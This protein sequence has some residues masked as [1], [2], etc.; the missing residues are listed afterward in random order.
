MNWLKRRYWN[1]VLAFAV[2]VGVLLGS[3]VS[4]GA[5]RDPAMDPHKGIREDTLRLIALGTPDDLLRL[6]DAF[7]KTEQEI[8]RLKLGAMQPEKQ[9]QLNAMRDRH[10]E[11]ETLLRLLDSSASE[12][13]DRD[14]DRSSAQE[15]ASLRARLVGR[16]EALQESIGVIEQAI[17]V[18]QAEYLRILEDERRAL[19]RFLAVRR[20]ELLQEFAR[21][22]GCLSSE[23]PCLARRFKT[24]CRLQPLL[25]V[26]ERAPILILQQEVA[27]QLDLGHRSVSSLCEYL[28]FDFAL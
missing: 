6:R 26:A 14:L 27:N 22:P 20:E 4:L 5:D 28:R 15:R 16:I 9:A 24:L 13:P 21:P 3:G 8:A 10:V 23:R 25:P 18:E 11:S 19:G 7:H 17:H 1:R 2:G 12:I